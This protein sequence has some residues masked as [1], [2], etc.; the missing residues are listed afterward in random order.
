MDVRMV[1]E[2]GTSPNEPIF[3]TGSARS[4]T[5]LFTRLLDGHPSLLVFPIELKY[6]R[7]RDIPTA[8]PASKLAALSEPRDIIQAIVDSPYLRPLLGETDTVGRR[9]EVLEAVRRAVDADVFRAALQPLDG[10]ASHR[11]AISHFFEA[12]L[13][14]LGRRRTDLD[15]IRFVEKTPLQEENVHELRRWFP[16]ARFVHLVRNPYAVAVSERKRTELGITK[17][18]VIRWQQSSLEYAL[19]NARSLGESSYRI[20]RFED[21]VS[22]PER[23]MRGAAEFL[24]IDDHPIL[25][26]PTVLGAPWGGNSST[27]STRFDGVARSVAEN[28]RGALLP[29]EVMAVNRFVGDLM[30]E[31]G[32]DRLPWP[33]LHHVAKGFRHPKAILRNSWRLIR[34]SNR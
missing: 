13:E 7:Y 18:H 24:G 29:M 14:G 11:D 10:I 28:W 23:T 16:G 9:D 26:A 22:D 6:F 3:V 31:F 1:R 8:Y 4:G 20:I 15:S 12:L 25:R 32:Y 19:E 2:P 21:L 30:S 34:R 27:T 33:P 5:T 17:I